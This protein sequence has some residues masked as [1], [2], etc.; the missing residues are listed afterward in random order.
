[1]PINP[2]EMW[3]ISHLLTGLTWL[4]NGQKINPEHFFNFADAQNANQH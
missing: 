4:T 2:P 3:I 1:M